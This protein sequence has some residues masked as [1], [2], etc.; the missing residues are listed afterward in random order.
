MCLLVSAASGLVYSVLSPHICSM[1]TITEE[2][3][4]WLSEHHLADVEQLLVDNGFF[5]L[6]CI[7]LISNEY[8][9]IIVYLYN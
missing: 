4:R 1:A 2:A 3:V 6:D 7:L 9:L 8:H 5:T